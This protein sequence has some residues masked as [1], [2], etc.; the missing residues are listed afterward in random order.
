M[1]LILFA[2]VLFFCLVVSI[3]LGFHK[4]FVSL[5]KQGNERYPDVFSA[6]WW[7]MIGL[8]A[9]LQIYSL[10]LPVNWVGLVAMAVIG[11]ASL[12]YAKDVVIKWREQLSSF[13]YLS[14]RNIVIFFLIVLSLG[15]LVYSASRK[16]T[17]YDTNLYHLNAMKW[18]SDYPAVPGLANIN[19]RLGINSSFFLF[20]ALTDFW[21]YT[22]S[23]SHIALSLLLAVV[24]VQWIY[25]IF[26][27]KSSF[28]TKIFCT[29]TMPVIFAGSWSSEVASLSTDLSM[30]V[31]FLVFCLYLLKKKGRDLLLLIG[32]SGLVLSF[33]LSGIFAIVIAMVYLGRNL[34]LSTG[35]LFRKRLVVASLALVLFTAG[36]FMARNAVVSGW[37]LFPSPIGKLGL[38]W[39]VPEAET[40]ELSATIMAWGRSP[41]PGYKNSVNKKFLEWFP[42]W[43]HSIKGKVEYRLFILGALLFAV[44][45]YFKS[46]KEIWRNLG[47]EWFLVLFLSMSSIFLFI[48]VAPMLRFGALFFWTFFF[49]ASLPVFFHFRKWLREPRML[50]IVSVFMTLFVTG[51]SPSLKDIPV[52]RQIKKEESFQ[53]RAVIASPEGETPELILWVPVKGDQCG[54]SQIPCGPEPVVVRQRK[55]GDISKGFLPYIKN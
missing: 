15:L 28:I 53:V 10:F 43:V 54:N 7:G 40:K 4:L 34:L 22:N 33:K 25:T 45:F 5:L 42:P 17:L 44:A 35:L 24:S 37:V 51:K 14:R 23:S 52:F 9:S 29:T 32:L 48:A 49:S 1:L 3:G 38:S 2:W 20:A 39:S 11:M 8:I 6:F 55:P 19:T 13:E 50:F 26:N 30:F 21:I 47:L 27:P 12:I 31:L 46:P 18:I 41:G 16:V 36:G